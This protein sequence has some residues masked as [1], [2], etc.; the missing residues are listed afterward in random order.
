MIELDL[1]APA[2]T[3]EVDSLAA[4]Y[5][6]FSPSDTLSLYLFRWEVNKSARLALVRHKHEKHNIP[7]AIER[8]N[9]L[10]ELLHQVLSRSNWLQK[11]DVAIFAAETSRGFQPKDGESSPNS[12]LVN[13]IEGLQALRNWTEDLLTNFEQADYP[14]N[15]QSRRFEALSRA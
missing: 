14:R 15:A 5:Y 1:N 6:G 10:T 4:D 13:I 8:A 7:D 11:E 12:H 3:Y 2:G 9:R